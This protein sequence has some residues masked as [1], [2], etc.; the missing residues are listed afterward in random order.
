MSCAGGLGAG[1]CVGVDF[2]SIGTMLWLGDSGTISLVLRIGHVVKVS[3]LAWSAASLV[4]VAPD[5]AG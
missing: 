2:A 4:R 1:A 3:L 5:I